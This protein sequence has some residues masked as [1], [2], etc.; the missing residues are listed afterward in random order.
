MDKVEEKQ[1]KEIQYWEGN[2]GSSG[3]KKRNLKG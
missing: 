1:Y 3:D 2:D